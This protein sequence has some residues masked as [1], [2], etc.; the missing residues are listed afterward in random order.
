MAAY[1]VCESFVLSSNLG[2]APLERR[3]FF[4]LD[5]DLIYIFLRN[6][7]GSAN[8]GEL[9]FRALALF[10]L[11]LLGHVGLPPHLLIVGPRQTYSRQRIEVSA[12]QLTTPSTPKTLVAR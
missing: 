5:S 7:H 6:Y 8:K 1:W 3:F 10:S 12:F 2:P 11:A 4:S 9:V